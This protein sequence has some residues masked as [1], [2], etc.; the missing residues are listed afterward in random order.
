M[1]VIPSGS[2]SNK[3]LKC[4]RHL[5]P[6]VFQILTS[7]LQELTTAVLMLFAITL[8]DLTTALVIR[9]ILETD[10]NA[11]VWQKTFFY[12]HFVTYYL[13]S[14][15]YGQVS[16]LSLCRKWDSAI[17]FMHGC[18]LFYMFRPK[19]NS[20]NRVSLLKRALQKSLNVIQNLKAKQKSGLQST[21]LE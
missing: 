16:S 1:L 20:L 6:F 21:D 10:E 5:T 15:L 2:M 4:K 13:T 7:V 11:K 3:T 12:F 19:V 9:D 14:F 18:V 8:K 17:H